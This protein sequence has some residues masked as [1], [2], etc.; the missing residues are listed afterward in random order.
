MGGQVFSSSHCKGL[1]T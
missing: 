1:K